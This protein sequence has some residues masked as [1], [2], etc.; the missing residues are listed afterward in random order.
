[1]H[2]E[3]WAG[4]FSPIGTTPIDWYWQAEDAT[5][6]A[7]KFAERKAA[8]AFFNGLDYA[9]GRFAYL[10]T[11]AD[12]PTGYAGETVSATNGALRVL[13]MRRA[14]QAAAYLWVQNRNHTWATA[15]AATTPAS[16][17]VAIGGLQN[18]AYRVELWS[19]TTG[20]IL[21]ASSATPSAGALSIPISNLAD[22]VAIK[23]Y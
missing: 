7:A 9:G 5:A 20:A 21:S 18:R 4:L 23:I 2:N 13:A 6:T 8:S 16:G 1:M 19:T 10:M 14:D 3:M 15:P 17:A 12:A 11:P 22:D